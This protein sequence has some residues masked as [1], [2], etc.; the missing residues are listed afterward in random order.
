M[1]LKAAPL[2]KQI[3]ESMNK[4]M[5]M[6]TQETAFCLLSISKFVG[7]SG[8]SSSVNIT[9][10]INGSAEVAKTSKRSIALID[11]NLKGS[12]AKGKIKIRNK[13]NSLL[14]AKIVLKGTPEA[15]QEKAAQNNLKIDIL[16]KDLK[17]GKI[18]PTKLEQGTDFIAE[19]TVT[20][21]G[22]TGNYFNMVLSN[23]F[24]SGWE[25]HNT[26]MDTYTGRV[27]MAGFNYQDIRDD[28]VYIFFDIN[29]KSKKTYNV[30]LNASYLG[31]FYLPSVV[32]EA[33]YDNS[34]YART[35]GKWVE[36]IPYNEKTTAK[37]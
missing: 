30:L 15:G 8:T 5:W 3:S 20:N 28:R 6:S 33:M 35:V 24:P 22:L 29:S 26:R 36:V 10:S 7:G 37:K 18:D 13:G 1:K 14:Y 16:Y 17:G 12:A 21:T 9:Y 19:V 32:C 11:M 31:K 34:I 27:E 2:I 23:I 4:D 25:I